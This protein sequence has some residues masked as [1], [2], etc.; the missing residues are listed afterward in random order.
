M[1]LKITSQRLQRT[2]QSLNLLALALAGCVSVPGN[3]EKMSPDQ[4]REWARDK[5]ANIACG[6][7]N[8]PYGRGIATYV[9]LDKG[10]VFNGSVS[11]DPECKIT[12]TNETHPKPAAIQPVP[13]TIVPPPIR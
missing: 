5:N 12:V 10:V 7:I 6:V 1:K 9:V 11:V 3:P 2:F 8:S 13:V 4:L